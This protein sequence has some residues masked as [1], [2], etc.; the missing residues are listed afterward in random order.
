MFRN[1]LGLLAA[2]VLFGFCS[3]SALA[4]DLDSDRIFH[5]TDPLASRDSWG[6]LTQPPL[7]ATDFAPRYPSRFFYYFQS[8]RGLVEDQ[9]YVGA[10]QVNLRRLGYYSGPIDGFFSPEVSHAICRLQKAEAMRVTGTLT[11]PVRR[12]LHLP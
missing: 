8:G 5:H 3:G 9:A 7:N 10:L 6:L 2:A 4:F 11:V 1:R 12:V